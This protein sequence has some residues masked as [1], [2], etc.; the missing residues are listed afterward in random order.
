M[1]NQWP[2]PK[3]PRARPSRRLY[4]NTFALSPDKPYTV[5]TVS[6]RFAGLNWEKTLSAQATDLPFPRYAC[7][8][9]RNFRFAGDT[10]RIIETPRYVLYWNRRS[11]GKSRPA[12]VA[13]SGGAAPMK[14]R[15]APGS[16]SAL[17]GSRERI[18]RNV[19]SVRISEREL[20]GLSV[21]IHMWLLFEPSD[22]RACPLKRQVEII[23]T[24]E[25]QEPVAGCPVIGAHQ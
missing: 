11:D 9:S 14:P 13:S 7:V 1:H 25:Q 3:S 24:E 20:L 6:H 15:P 17:S 21:R 4:E 8:L 5:P 2:T 10:I 19:I 16:C 23:D 18:D 22:E 12:R